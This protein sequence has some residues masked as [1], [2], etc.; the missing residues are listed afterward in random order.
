MRRMRNINTQ[1]MLIVVFAVLFLAPVARANTLAFAVYVDNTLRFSGLD[2]V[3][4][5]FNPA[6]GIIQIGTPTAPLMILGLQFF[7]EIA[8]SNSPGSAA[9]SQIASSGLQVINTSGAGHSVIV[10]FTDR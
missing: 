6:F 10:S 8:A 1:V 9:L 7:G 3:F 5:D 4:G 2:N